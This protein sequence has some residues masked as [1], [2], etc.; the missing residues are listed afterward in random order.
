MGFGLPAAIGAKLACPGA[1]VV[2]IDGDGSL[3]MTINELAT[4]RRH[5][6][7]VKVMVVNNQMLGMVRQWQ[8]LIYHG[9]RVVSTL[10][11][12]AA[13]Y[14]DFLAIAAGYGVK[15]ERV[16]AP[17]MLGPA[18]ARM[19]HDPDEPYLL[20]VLVRREDDVFPMIPSGRSYRDVIFT[21]AGQPL[22]D[23]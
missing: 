21:A 9:N 2:D 5:E 12:G 13:P 7:G 1:T 19:L 14:P 11:E 3:N 4:C 18:I 6:I 23:T 8:D 22:H 10:G 16:C 17:Q 20:D 15:A